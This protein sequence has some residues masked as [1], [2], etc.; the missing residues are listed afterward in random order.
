MILNVCYLIIIGARRIWFIGSSIVYWAR[1]G[2]SSRPGGP[3][4]NLQNT[5]ASIAWFGQRGMKWEAFS[6]AI[7]QFLSIYP[8]P[9]FIIIQLGSNDLGVSKGFE[10]INNIECD[11]LRLRV[12]LPNVKIIWSEILQRRYW[13]FADDGRSVEATR[14]RVNLAVKNLVI[15]LDGC[16]IRHSN[17]RAREINLYR[18]D[19]THLSDIGINVYLNTI[20]AALEYFISS[21]PSQFR[22]QIEP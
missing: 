2:S 20:Q 1:R 18:Y 3:N 6:S 16:V 15:S 21:G 14:K 5:G 11:L 17:I 19:G 4:L 22:H 9:N 13:H 10:L 7:D 8:T 12:L